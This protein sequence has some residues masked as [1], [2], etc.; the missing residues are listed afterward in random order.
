MEE[1]HKNIGGGAEQRWQ[2]WTLESLASGLA[3]FSCFQIDGLS[4]DFNCPHGEKLG[5]KSTPSLNRSGSLSDYFNPSELWSSAEVSPEDEAKM[6]PEKPDNTSLTKQDLLNLGTD[7]KSYFT[8]LIAQKLSPIL[9]QLSDLTSTLK[10]IS[11][12]ADSWYGYG[13][14]SYC[15]RGN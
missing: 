13:N 15:L 10:E 3:S 9:Q 8:T 14:W 12:T 5:G 6:A 4:R 7:L 1:I 2:W 11:S